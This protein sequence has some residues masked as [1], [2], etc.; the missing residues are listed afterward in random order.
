MRVL[1]NGWYNHGNTGDESYKLTFP[2]VFPG[3]SFEFIDHIPKNHQADAYILGG[4]NVLEPE[5]LNQYQNINKPKHLIS[6]S[7]F[8]NIDKKL[9]EGF[10]QVVVRDVRSKKTLEDKGIKCKLMPDLAFNF[11][12]EAEEGYMLLRNMYRAAD[13]KIYNKIVTVI[14]N[15]YVAVSAPDQRKSKHELAFLKFC[16]D[17]AEIFDNTAASFVFLPFST[18]FPSD[19]RVA[20]SWV[21]AKCKYW[22]KNLVIYDKLS[23][24][25]TLNIIGA[26]DA[27]ISMRLHSSIFSCVAN[28]PFVDI[29]HHDKNLGFL[30]TIG[31]T[32]LS[33][34]YWNF[35][36]EK[37]HKL[38]NDLLKTPEPLKTELRKISI[39]QKRQLAEVSKNVCLCK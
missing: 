33:I 29:T 12:A 34:S 20:N 35:D 2:A 37:C 32:D 18:R 11:Q 3:H 26:S 24:Q 38:L 30:E 17:L 25:D 19:D 22:E 6:V 7:A 1:V 36:K 39:E 16:Y 27:V 8:S 15:S 28:T 14:V 4:G 5:F 10:D 9:L 21:A 13:Y 31:K 23:V